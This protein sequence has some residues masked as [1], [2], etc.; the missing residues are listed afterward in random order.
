[1]LYVKCNKYPDRLENG[2]LIN[3]LDNAINESTTAYE[4][5]DKQMKVKNRQ[6]CSCANRKVQIITY[7]PCMAS[8]KVV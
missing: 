1:M 4:D 5:N 7:V 8:L 2:Y 3:E 6:K